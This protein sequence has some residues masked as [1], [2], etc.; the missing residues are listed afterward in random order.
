MTRETAWRHWRRGTPM[1][2]L[3]TLMGLPLLEI[4]EMIRKK[5]IARDA[6]RRR[7]AA[8]QRKS[9]RRAAKQRRQP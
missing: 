6:K 2:E 9:K 4:E 3:A 8:A 1:S 5:L 7:R